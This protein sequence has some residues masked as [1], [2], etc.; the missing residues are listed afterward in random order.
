MYNCDI[1]STAFHSIVS[2]KSVANTSMS[3]RQ[4]AEIQFYGILNDPQGSLPMYSRSANVMSVNEI[5]KQLNTPPFIIE[6]LLKVINSLSNRNNS[7]LMSE[8]NVINL[9]RVL[10]STLDV[11]ILLFF[12][13][14]D[15]NSDNLLIKNE[16]T[17]W[18]QL[19]L[20][21]IR[22]DSDILQEAVRTLVERFFSGEV[23]F[24]FVYFH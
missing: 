15:E 10:N 7:S 11:R 24:E 22:I 3:R 17:Q 16:M 8:R 4:V 6:R 21:S 20:K 12:M 19:Y 13:M 5:A 2:F 9:T 18:F 23:S 1:A 14:L